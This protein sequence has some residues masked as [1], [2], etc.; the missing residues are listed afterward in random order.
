MLDNLTSMLY[1]AFMMNNKV[2]TPGEIFLGDKDY[3][4]KN[5]WKVN[6]WLFVATLISC[7]CDIIFP[8]TVRQWPI[9]W[10]V[11]I[12]GAQFAAIALWAHGL[13]KWIRG[14]DEMHRRITT[15]AVLF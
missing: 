13:T 10:R 4:L 7:F 9:E 5:D 8:A 6:G 2:N 12:V 3:T 14:M 11:V 1:T 15:S